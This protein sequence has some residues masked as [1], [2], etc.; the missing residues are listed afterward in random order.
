[1]T[2]N[3][4][5]IYKYLS[6]NYKN[7]I[8]L[9]NIKQI[10]LYYNMHTHINAYKIIHVIHCKLNKIRRSL[11]VK[12]TIICV[13]NYTKIVNLYYLQF[14]SIHFPDKP[15]PEQILVTMQSSVL[16]KQ[17]YPQMETTGV[18]SILD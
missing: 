14:H 8:A 15:L 10:K 3:T 18:D 13:I 5:N 7:L 4:N 2:N 12:T 1:M 6:T 16:S 17:S 9:Y 11:S